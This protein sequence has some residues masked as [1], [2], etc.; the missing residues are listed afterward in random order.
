[1]FF[2][3][4]F[5]EKKHF[6]SGLFSKDFVTADMPELDKNAF[7]GSQVRDQRLELLSRLAEIKIDASPEGALSRGHDAVHPVLRK[8]RNLLGEDCHIALD[9]ISAQPGADAM[10]FI[11]RAQTSR[12][13]QREIAS[14]NRWAEGGAL[15]WKTY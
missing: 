1:M 2:A 6:M 11:R 8:L 7:T 15:I 5:L 12:Q 3:F 4:Y 10:T 14:L 13:V 9:I